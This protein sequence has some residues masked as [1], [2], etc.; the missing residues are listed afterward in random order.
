MAT[1]RIMMQVVWWC[2][3]GIFLIG[4][5]A[6]LGHVLHVPCLYT[7][8]WPDAKGMSV[9]SAVVFMVNALMQLSMV[10]VLA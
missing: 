3:S 10:K 9:P 8:G 6:L 4:T 5:V 2:A 7:W 1:R